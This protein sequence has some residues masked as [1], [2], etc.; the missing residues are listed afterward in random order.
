MRPETDLPERVCDV[1]VAGAGLAGL[2]AAIAFA[3][4][5]FDVVA[6]GGDERLAR[7]RTVA[8]LDRSIAY[9]EQLGVWP[10]VEPK[11]APMRTLRLID[12][13]GGL[14]PPRP[15]EFLCSEIGLETF[16]WN[17]ENDLMADTLVACA[18]ATG[19]LERRPQSVATYDFSGERAVVRLDDGRAVAAALVIGADGRASPARRAAGLA[20]RARRYPQS[21]LTVFLSHRLPH[22]D[23][24]TEFHTREGPF[25][26]VPLPP[27]ACAPNRSSLVWVMSDTQASRREALDDTALAREIERQARSM[28]G[29]MWID[30]RRG[31]FPMIR[32]VVPKLTA[33]R[34]ALVGDAA[35]AF[36]PIGA[37][38]LNLGLRDVEAIVE[39]AVAA[40]AEGRDI[41]GDAALKSY[42]SARRVDI[43]ARTGV[44]DG[45]NRA[46]LTRF[47][48]LD[49]ARG[50]GLAAL[51]A[52]APLRRLVMREGVAPRFGRP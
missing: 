27:R 25:T 30:G 42:Q 28:L 29:T 24:S 16:G 50:A 5:G 49:F 35:H 45:L 48:P 17:V 19:G 20:V 34:L 47:A 37:Q 38:G 51:G 36:P 3:R 52:V 46:L 22:C 4:A 7:G 44:V 26:L 40:R 43:L 32:Q 33:P 23:A 31:V 8:M 11:A 1:F 6:S 9:L 12:D 2:A 13:T 15:V 18:T 10:A 21:A 14:F 39:A 41:G